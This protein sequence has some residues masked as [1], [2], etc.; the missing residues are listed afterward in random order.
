MDKNAVASDIITHALPSIPFDGWSIA[1]LKKAAEEAGYKRTD[2]IRVFPGGAVDAVDAFSRTADAQM[3]K[4]FERYHADTMKIRER[5][6]TL[7][8]LRLMVHEDHREAVRKA[9]AL[10]AMPF[11]VHRGLKS[12]YET[13][14][15]IWHAAGDTSTDFNFY[16]KRL[17]LAGVFSSTMLVWLDDKSAGFEHTWAFLDR[18]IEDVMKIEKAKQ[19]A[20]RWFDSKTA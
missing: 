3:L 20:K 4:D 19:Q 18:R 11:Y 16:T 8:R 14:D 15:A 5:I 12:L 17:M 10:H 6:A 2:V 13:V 7:V 1:A 9:V